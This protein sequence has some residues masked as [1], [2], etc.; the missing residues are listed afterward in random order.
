MFLAT[1]NVIYSFANL[2]GICNGRPGIEP[3]REPGP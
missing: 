3:Q 1:G 2:G